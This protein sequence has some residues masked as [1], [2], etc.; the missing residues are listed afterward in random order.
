ML[1]IQKKKN[2][3]INYPCFNFIEKVNS[4][5]EENLRIVN[6]LQGLITIDRVKH[7]VMH[8]YVGLLFDRIKEHIKKDIKYE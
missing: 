8:K 5:N 1:Q 2:R 3:G 7:K 6:E 4:N